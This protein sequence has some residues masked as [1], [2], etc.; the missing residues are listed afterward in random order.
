MSETVTIIAAR[1]GKAVH[2][3][4]GA[5]IEIINPSGTQVVDTWAL[6]PPDLA[7]RLSMEHTRAVHKRLMPRVGDALYSS[8]RRPLLTITTD[9]SPG[10]HDTLIASCDPERYR[11]LGHVGHHDNC[12]DNFLAA[13]AELGLPPTAVPAPLNLFMNIPWEPDGTL[14]FEAPTSRPGDLIRMRAETDLVVVMSAC[15]QD[16]VPVNGVDQRPTEAAF[17]VIP[18][19]Q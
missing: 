19:G 12:H 4:A 10:L 11:M 3:P 5:E 17:R 13:L 8:E 9:T 7:E 1:R 6:C 16:M 18:A 2:L 15:P 14:R